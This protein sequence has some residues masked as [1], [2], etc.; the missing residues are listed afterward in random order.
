MAEGPFAKMSH[1]TQQHPAPQHS[2]PASSHL[3]LRPL[4]DAW[5]AASC[6]AWVRHAERAQ[7]PS[8]FQRRHQQVWFCKLIAVD[9]ECLPR[10][11]QEAAAAVAKKLENL[12]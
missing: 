5:P 3:D 12:G 2:L 11:G 8:R 1:P 4:A 7:L 10:K 9:A 6:H